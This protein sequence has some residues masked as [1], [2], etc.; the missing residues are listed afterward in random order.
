M[1]RP[2]LSQWFTREPPTSVAQVRIDT[3]VKPQWV[4]PK[5]GVLEGTSPI[6]TVHAVKLPAG[7]TIYE[8]PVGY[9]GGP[10][11]GGQDIKQIFVSKPWSIDG[12]EVISSEP[13]R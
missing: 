8:G 11:L 6:N 12:V 10:Y 9:Q 5:T 1:Q 2:T 7:T 3:A 4:N 13:L